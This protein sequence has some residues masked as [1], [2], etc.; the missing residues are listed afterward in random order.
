MSEHWKEFDLEPE[1]YA[2]QSRG[3]VEA[4]DEAG[5]EAGAELVKGFVG[6][7][8]V[9]GCLFLVPTLGYLISTGVALAVAAMLV[10]SKRSK[11]RRPSRPGGSGGNGRRLGRV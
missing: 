5:G 6:A 10:L 2:L 7:T 1:E 8:L 3:S 4:E 11:S 9:V